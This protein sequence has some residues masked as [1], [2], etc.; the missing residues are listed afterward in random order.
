M[1]PAKCSDEKFC[2]SIDNDKRSLPGADRR[3][4]NVGVFQANNFPPVLLVNK[5]IS[6]N[7][8]AWKSRENFPFYDSRRLLIL[9]YEGFLYK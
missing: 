5:R 7:S 9:Y 6:G 2:P 1:I 4:D 8:I 3:R